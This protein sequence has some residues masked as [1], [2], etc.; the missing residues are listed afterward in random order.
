MLTLVGAI[1]VAVTVL[2]LPWGSW[3]TSADPDASAGFF[4][5]R[6]ELRPLSEPVQDAYFAW[7]FAVF[8]VLC[9]VAV[10]VARARRRP[11]VAIPAV[12][13]VLVAGC[14]IWHQ[15]GIGT[16]TDLFASVYVPL[17]GALLV[18]AGLIAAAVA[19]SREQP[20]Q[21]I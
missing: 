12:L 13:A 21:P 14:G 17:L 19:S 6:S 4:R 10:A 1:L 9:V 8:V 11:P 18:V 2:L 20:V 7:G 3:G 16:L 15:V 5:L